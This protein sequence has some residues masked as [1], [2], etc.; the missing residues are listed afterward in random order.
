[1]FNINASPELRNLADRYKDLVSD[2]RQG[3]HYLALKMLFAYFIGEYD[4]SVDLIRNNAWAMSESHFLAIIQSF[5]GNRFMRR[6]R[7]SVLGHYKGELDPGRFV[8]AADDTD[9]PKYSKFL[10]NIQTWKCSK[11]SYHGQ[12]VLVI[13]LVD[14][15]SKFALPLYYHICAPKD[16]QKETG[17]GNE[18]DVAF[19]L[20]MKAVKKFGSIPVVADSWFDSGDLALKLRNNGVIFV[21]ELKSKRKAKVHPGRSEAWVAL[22]DL[23]VWSQ[24]SAVISNTTKWIASSTIVLKSHKFMVKS[25][26]VF[27]RKNGETPFAFYAS[28]D[29]SMSPERIWLISRARWKIECMFRDLKSHLGFGR[30]STSFDSVNDLAVVIPFVIITQFRLNLGAYG[31]KDGS[32]ISG[33]IETL[34]KRR[35]DKTIDLLL[36]GFDQD[37][38]ELIQRRRSRIN[39]KPVSQ[40]AEGKRAA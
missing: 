4:S 40:A 28:T 35:E 6:L 31:L 20:I 23:P 36:A 16:V 19:D 5:D 25:V 17:E 18:L 2:A 15:K 33:C 3:T 12:K 39:Q 29:K 37:K 11:G 7:N 8:I 24:R 30:I 14:E 38:L 34:K 27:N 32:T 9:N 26:A 22:S 21:W 13:C 10:K 1:M